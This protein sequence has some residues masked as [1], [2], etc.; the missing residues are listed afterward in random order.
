MAAS[1]TTSVT[2]KVPGGGNTVGPVSYKFKGQANSLHAA[3]VTKY[4]QKTKIALTNAERKVKF[5]SEHVFGGRLWDRLAKEA[6]K[7][8]ADYK[9]E[10]IANYL[11]EMGLEI[12]K[13]RVV[14]KR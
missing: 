5:I 12:V 8:M 13:G 6:K 14:P 11:E 2:L 10:F 1:V 3:I 7:T 9:K 4:K